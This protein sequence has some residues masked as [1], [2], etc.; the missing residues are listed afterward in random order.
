MSRVAIVSAKSTA[1]GSF[2]GSLKDIT[3]ATHGAG[4]VKK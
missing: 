3:A 4:V 1:I 2:G